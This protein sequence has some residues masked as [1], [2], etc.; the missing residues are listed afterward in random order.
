[1]S[2][3]KDSSTSISTIEPQKEFLVHYWLSRHCIDSCRWILVLP[4]RSAKKH[5]RGLQPS[6]LLKPQE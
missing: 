3:T 4:I 2:S 5:E 6:Q 1:M